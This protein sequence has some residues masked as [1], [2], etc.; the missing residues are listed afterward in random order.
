[1]LNGA[2]PPK[3]CTAHHIRMLPAWG[4]NAGCLAKC[5][6]RSPD[7]CPQPCGGELMPRH[8]RRP[9]GGRRRAQHVGGG[10]GAA[11]PDGDAEGV[12]AAARGACVMVMPCRWRY[13]EAGLQH[14]SRSAGH[15]Q[16][17]CALD[18][19]LCWMCIWFSCGYL[20]L[21]AG[22]QKA[23]QSCSPCALALA[24]ICR[25]QP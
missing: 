21:M 20:H 2:S 22:L 7:V 3:L 19:S 11:A 1:M 6:N 8:T 13:V 23:G 18:I 25:V 24:G 5:L 10:G 17:V 16:P 12:A 14:C 9:R 15:M 4:V